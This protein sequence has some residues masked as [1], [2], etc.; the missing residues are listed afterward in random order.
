MPSCSHPR[1]ARP[2]LGIQRLG[3]AILMS[4]KNLIIGAIVLLVGYWMF[5]DPSGLASTAQDGASS[6]MDLSGQAMEGLID[7]IKQVA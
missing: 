1:F 2:I 7:F 6:A 5:T 4:K 3:R